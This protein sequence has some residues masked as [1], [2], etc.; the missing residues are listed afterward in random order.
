MQFHCELRL[1]ALILSAALFQVNRAVARGLL[2]SS[3][4]TC[5]GETMNVFR[6]CLYDEIRSDFRVCVGAPPLAGRAY[7][8][9]VVALTDVHLAE[10]RKR[11][12]SRE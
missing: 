8:L 3:V 10:L 9:A 12:P 5:H 11:K 1:I 7:W 2:Y 6:Q 4:C